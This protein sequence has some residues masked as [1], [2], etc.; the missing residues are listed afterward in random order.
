MY[1]DGQF[2]AAAAGQVVLS[3]PGGAALAG[4]QRRSEVE[5][6]LSRHFGTRLSL[7][8]ERRD[9]DGSPDGAE[10]GL[11]PSAGADDEEVGD[12][13]ALEDA[14]TATTGVAGSP[15]PSP[16]PS[17]WRSRDPGSTGPTLPG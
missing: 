17:C 12:V 14:P 13:H 4:E 2:V 5:A 9:E 10:V 1:A 15:R 3:L 8:L 6:A 11:P 16:A 7:R